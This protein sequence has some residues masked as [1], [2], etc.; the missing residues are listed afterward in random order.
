[1]ASISSGT[2]ARNHEATLYVGELP[3]KVDEA[4]LWELMLQAG[5]VNSVYIPRDK[6]TKEHNNF[7]FVEFQNSYD[8]DYAL[9]LLGGVRLYGQVL[10]MNKTTHSA[11][12][13]KPVN[14]VG[15]NLFVGN[16]DSEVDEKVLY[17]T[18]SRFGVLVAAPKLMRDPSNYSS[19]GYAFINYDS[20]E[21]SDAAIES[22]NGQ[23]LAGKPISVT[24]A[25]KKDSKTERHG[26][27][28]ERILAANNPN[29]QFARMRQQQADALAAQYSR[30]TKPGQSFA[31]P[32]SYAPPPGY[33]PQAMAA[34][35]PPPGMAP[36]GAAV[37]P[38]PGM[39]PPGAPVRPP[40]MMM[41]PGMPPG[42]PPGMMPPG[43][44]PGPPPGMMPPGM[45]P[46]PPPGMMPPGLPPSSVQ[47]LPPHLRPPGM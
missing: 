23:F 19:K 47:N 37:R 16:L 30:V 31:P 11:A 28:A 26:S 44:P 27:M 6:L 22:M 9:K 34:P 12:A 1:M 24:Y 2:D 4:L 29:R 32:P 41:P 10:R 13:S 38:P 21:A 17:D 39:A 5:P 46:G 15:A 18:F 40:G 42:P 35:A 33:A 43:M 14:D 7:G 36:P 3:S 8:A 20:F 45:P 25:L